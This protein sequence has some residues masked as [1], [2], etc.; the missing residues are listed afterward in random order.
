[1]V[2]RTRHSPL[3]RPSPQNPRL[4]ESV[5]HPYPDSRRLNPEVYNPTIPHL[6][7]VHPQ[8]HKQPFISTQT[9]LVNEVMGPFSLLHVH[10]T[11]HPNEREQGPRVTIEEV[12]VDDGTVNEMTHSQSQ[13]QLAAPEGLPNVSNGSSTESIPRPASA[14]PIIHHSGLEADRHDG[15][16][17]A[18]FGGIND[19]RDDRV[20]YV[21]FNSTLLSRLSSFLAWRRL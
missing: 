16:D 6:Y 17:E 18:L 4:T 13:P 10:A 15:G 1:M 12:R 9:A 5:L 19:L 2:K 21:Q 11:T 20:G 3:T 7:C 14:P 8:G